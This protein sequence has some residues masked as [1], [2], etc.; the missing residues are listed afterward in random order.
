[1]IALRKLQLALGFS[2]AISWGNNAVARNQNDYY[3]ACGDSEYKCCLD[4]SSP[5][6]LWWYSVTTDDSACPTL[7][8]ASNK[9]SKTST[10][11]YASNPT[12]YLPSGCTFND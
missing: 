12:A 8:H 7:T 6:S 4:S 10:V 5:P 1:M 2:L 3:A 9:C 11:I